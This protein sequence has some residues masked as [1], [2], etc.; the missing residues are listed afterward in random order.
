MILY[1]ACSARKCVGSTDTQSAP[2]D[3]IAECEST[4]HGYRKVV[5]LTTFVGVPQTTLRTVLQ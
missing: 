1:S 3:S 4:Y 2:V 5:I